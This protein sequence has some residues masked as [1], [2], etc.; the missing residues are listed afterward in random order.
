MCHAYC[1]GS[2][3]GWKKM[4]FQ[5]ALNK[6]FCPTTQPKIKASPKKKN[7][8]NNAFCLPLIGFPYK[9]HNIKI[10]K[11]ISISF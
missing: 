4:S 9:V 8:Q 7:K 5:L 10:K 11:Q 3:P 1:L 2:H 6:T